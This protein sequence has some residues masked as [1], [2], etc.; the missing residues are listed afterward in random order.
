MI[1]SFLAQSTN[2]HRL[3]LSDET[4]R[5]TW[6]DMHARIAAFA[7]HFRASGV[8]AGDPVLITLPKGCDAVCAL[9]AALAIGAIAVPLDYRTPDRRKASVIERMAPRLEVTQAIADAV[10]AG[11]PDAASFQPTAIEPGHPALVLMSSGTTGTPKAITI[12]HGNLSA[13]VTWAT[14][15]FSLGS[16]DHILSV[17][18]LHFDLAT[19]DI[20]AGL[21]AGAH[22]HLLSEIEASFPAKVATV[23]RREGATLIYA[24]PTVYAM[25]ARLHETAMP[26]FRW[27]LFAGEVMSAPTLQALRRFAPNARLANLYGPSE[28]NVV[29][30]HEVT[31]A[32][33]SL[34][35]IGRPCSGA[36]VWIADAEGHS[37]PV[38]EEGEICVE[39]PSVFLGYWGDQD[40]T[41]GTRLD[42]R[43]TTYRTGDYGW[44]DASDILHL[45][46]R[47]DRQ[48]KVRGILVSLDEI[49]AVASQSHL[50]QAC[51][52]VQYSS[53][54]IDT[55][56]HLF[57]VVDD[58]T[59]DARKEVRDWLCGRLPRV[60]VPGRITVVEALPRTLNGKIDRQALDSKSK[61]IQRGHW[62]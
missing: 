44:Q 30:W 15:A 62:L 18:P 56:L 11:A 28:T 20:F 54:L 24:V 46:G 33:T 53:G 38:G 2:P 37:V 31:E 48:I 35:P 5:L 10:R 32:D 26:A 51:A 57:I 13:F 50:V 22:V 14:E 39:G 23:S 61:E 43:A 9:L 34:V 8:K 19:F 40:R 42:G 58:R 1:V 4:E 17:A 12:S 60:C 49:E 16:S 25:I 55:N 45:S 41:L 7:D 21:G 3:A 6:A 36:R 47:R 27:V 52:V 59:V 29:T